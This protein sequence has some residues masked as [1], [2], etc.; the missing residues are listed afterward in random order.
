M[1]LFFVC[2][3]TF[4][5][6]KWV[7]HNSDTYLADFL[8]ILRFVKHKDTCQFQL[9]LIRKA[10]RISIFFFFENTQSNQKLVHKFLSHI[11]LCNAPRDQAAYHN[12][13]FGHVQGVLI[14]QYAETQAFITLVESDNLKKGSF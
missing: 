4:I 12:H 6:K 3:V 9:I 14:V 8:N 11:Y 5:G 2:L 10:A 13:G 7:S 1:E